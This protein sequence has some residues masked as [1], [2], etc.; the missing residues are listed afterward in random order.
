MV[1]TAAGFDSRL[2][3]CLC[4]VCTFSPCLCGFPPT[5]QK[6]CKLGELAMLNSPRCTQTCTGVV[7]TRGF[8]Q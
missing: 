3:H 5:V 7:A 6:M 4:G 1:S 8:S 2:G